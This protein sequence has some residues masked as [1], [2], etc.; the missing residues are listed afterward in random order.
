M[1]LN[2]LNDSLKNNKVIEEYNPNKNLKL[3]IVF[4]DMIADMLSK[5]KLNPIVTELFLEEEN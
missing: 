4:G 5:K 1:A 3:L 2:Y